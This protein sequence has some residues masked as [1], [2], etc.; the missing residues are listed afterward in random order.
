MFSSLLPYTFVCGSQ[1]CSGVINNTY[2]QYRTC[3]RLGV[4]VSKYENMPFIF[5]AIL[6]L[7]FKNIIA[8]S[9][10]DGSDTCILGL[11]LITTPVSLNMNRGIRLIYIYG[12]YIAF[13]TM[14]KYSLLVY[15]HVYINAASTRGTFF[16]DSYSSVNGQTSI[17]TPVRPMKYQFFPTTTML[18]CESSY[19]IDFPSV[20]MASISKSPLSVSAII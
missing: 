9:S 7:S 18:V 12:T 14:I 13:L 8:W 16:K 10:I 11:S 15:S 6:I 3:S 2:S 19:V 4:V 1:L 5:R 17:F 20:S